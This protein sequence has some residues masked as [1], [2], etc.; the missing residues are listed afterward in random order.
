MTCKGKSLENQAFFSYTLKYSHQIA[1]EFLSC[2][3]LLSVSVK[4]ICLCSLPTNSGNSFMLLSALTL[5][6]H[7]LKFPQTEASSASL[8]FWNIDIS[9]IKTDILGSRE[10]PRGISYV[11]STLKLQCQFHPEFI[12]TEARVASQKQASADFQVCWKQCYQSHLECREMV[13]SAFSWD[14]QKTRE[15]LPLSAW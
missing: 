1:A 14:A 2:K 9:Y 15:Q 6:D 7:L 4:I 12:E 10:V 5:R 8:V 13:E 3:Y 11:S